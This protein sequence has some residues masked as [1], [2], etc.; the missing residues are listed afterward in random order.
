MVFLCLKSVMATL[1][2]TSGKRLYLSFCYLGRRYRRS[3][4]EVERR[5]ARNILAKVSTLL[6][7]A[8]TGMICVPKEGDAGDFFFA[9]RI[10]AHYQPALPRVSLAEFIRQYLELHQPPIK[11]AST[12]MTERIQLK[13][14]ERAVP[15][16]YLA[17]L[18]LE[19]L[20]EYRQRRAAE[21]TPLTINKEMATI[22]F[23]LEW[24]KGR[25]WLL[26][27]PASALKPLKVEGARP[28]FLTTAELREIEQV[29][30][31]PAEKKKVRHSRILSLAE[32]EQLCQMARLS[33]P[34]LAPLVICAAYTG[35]R[36]GE[37]QRLQWQNVN[38]ARGFLVAHSHKQSQR[39]RALS[40]EIPLHPVLKETL[41][42]LK[43]QA[44]VTCPYVFHQQ[45]KPFT[46]QQLCWKFQKLVAGSPFAGLGWHVLRHSFA[47]NLAAAGVDQRVI[48]ELMGHTNEEMAKRYRHLL[49]DQK[50][51]AIAC[52]TRPGET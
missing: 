48:N 14:F 46:M 29:P 31:S 47:S 4:G 17:D 32:I 22:R 34:S 42:E 2:H 11:A 9:A 8:K 36:R 12:V 33:L 49:P 41:R 44:L 37:L 26:E 51:A 18:R 7:L 21:V 45:G 5:Q 1:Y 3:L 28:R 23:A 27:N 19:H 50:R 52:L 20:E 13:H 40:R 24:A 16:D 35:M 10:E 15:V 25:R 30:L 43:K 38:L 6:A 39:K